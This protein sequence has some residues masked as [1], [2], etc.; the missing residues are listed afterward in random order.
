VEHGEREE[1]EEVRGEVVSEE[2]L[3]ERSRIVGG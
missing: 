1:E 2:V 3:G